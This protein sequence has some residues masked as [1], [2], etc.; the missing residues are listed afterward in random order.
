MF[1][2]SQRPAHFVTIISETTK[3]D[4]DTV[5]VEIVRPSAVFA[6][7]SAF[8]ELK[9]SPEALTNIK[10]MVACKDYA[11]LFA[12][13]AAAKGK[14]TLTLDGAAITLLAGR[15]FFASMTDLLGKKAPSA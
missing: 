7:D 13:V 4:K 11:S 10:H 9:L 5:T 15:H 8:A 3:V 1:P 2:A 6:P 14:L 12:S